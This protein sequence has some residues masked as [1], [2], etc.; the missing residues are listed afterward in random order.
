MIII[1]TDQNGNST[2]S[3]EP[4]KS[5]NYY[6]KEWNAYNQA[7]DRAQEQGLQWTAEQSETYAVYSEARENGSFTP[8]L[9]G[10][11][12]SFFGWPLDQ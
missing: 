1:D 5:S 8:T 12:R 7:C 10:R 3:I 9:Q 2:I 6:C 11:V 4:D